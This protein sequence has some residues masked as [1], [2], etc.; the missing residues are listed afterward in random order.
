[1]LL[2]TYQDPYEPNKHHSLLNLTAFDDNWV[3]LAGIP[4][5]IY[6]GDGHDIVRASSGNDVLAGGAEVKDTLA[7][8]G[9]QEFHRKRGGDVLDPEHGTTYR[10]RLQPLNGGKELQLRGYLGPFYRTQTWIRVE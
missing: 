3:G 1:M 10:V 4:Y 2:V 6:G 8:P 5:F 7:R 9:L